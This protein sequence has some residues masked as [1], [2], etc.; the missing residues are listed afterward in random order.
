MITAIALKDGTLWV[1]AEGRDHRG[2]PVHG[3]ACCPLPHW[4]SRQAVLTMIDA[5]MMEAEA[6]I[7]RQID[8]AKESQ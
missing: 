6:H 7:Q 8:Y 5:A 2:L 1:G 3:S 4:A